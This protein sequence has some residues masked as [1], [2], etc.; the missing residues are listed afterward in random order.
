MVS[1][2]KTHI[3]ILQTDRQTNRRKAQK[4]Q[5]VGENFEIWWPQMTRNVFKLSTMVE[6]NFE[7]CLSQIAKNVLKLSTMVGE[8][9]EICWPQMARNVFKLSTMVGEKFEICWPQMA[10]MHLK[11]NRQK[12]FNDILTTETQ[13]YQDLA[14]F[15]K[16]S[17]QYYGIKT[18]S[19]ISWLY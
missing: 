17:K 19:L 2:Y 13:K 14:K 10:K 15:Y 11:L 5:K 9:F 6:E 1:G 3:P 8:N 12:S 16:I 7:I 4:A 18:T